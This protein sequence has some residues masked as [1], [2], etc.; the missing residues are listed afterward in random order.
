M[1]FVPSDQLDG[2]GLSREGLGTISGMMLFSAVMLV[3]AVLTPFTH[4]TILAVLSIALTG[5]AIY[6]FRDPERSIPERAD[7]VVSPADGKIIEMVEVTEREFIHG[8]ATRVSIF[9]SVFD[10]HVNRIPMS[11]EVGYFQY[12]R[13]AFVQA[14]RSH[15][16][17]INEQTIIGIANGETKLLFKQ[18]AG[19]LARR[20]VCNVREG[21]R[22]TRGERFGIIKFGSRVD[23]FLP[24]NVEVMV[25]LNQKV[26]GG[27][28]ILGVI[29]HDQ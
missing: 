28:S 14:F 9:L 17:D 20:I 23:V 5:L 6:F 8:P 29:K 4:L 24:K 15:A 22:V 27:E 7:A 1:N 18:I 12:K 19:I 13:G 2:G 10:V 26:K 11:G 16:S 3:G 25:S 21:Y